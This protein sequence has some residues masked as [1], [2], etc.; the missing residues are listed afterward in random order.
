MLIGAIILTVGTP[1][2]IL[3]RMKK[4]TSTST[5]KKTQKKTQN[6]TQNETND[7]EEM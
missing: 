1:D 3:S 6:E 2:K 7:K 5:K 4:N